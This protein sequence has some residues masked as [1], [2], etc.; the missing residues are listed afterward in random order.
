[1]RT[2]KN[3]SLTLLLIV[4]TSFVT[5]S[6]ILVTESFGSTP[7]VKK[8]SYDVKGKGQFVHATIHNGKVIPRVSLPVVT[9]TAKRNTKNMFATAEKGKSIIAVVN[10][11]E[12]VITS[13]KKNTNYK[14][15]AACAK[16][17][18]LPVVDLP[19]VLIVAERMNA[20]SFTWLKTNK[21]KIP[22]VDLPEV[23]ISADLPGYNKVAA[24]LYK[25]YYIPVVDLPE[26]EITAKRPND[27][28]T[29]ND[30]N[31]DVNNDNLNSDYLERVESKTNQ[32][33]SAIVLIIAKTIFLK[34]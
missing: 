19:E 4:L 1:M 14:L 22:V 10:L 7:A 33:L 21:H 32:S 26:V 27:L 2:L 6:A 18:N 20:G 25:G 16:D 12:I 5:Y 34:F 9:I 8:S 11:P 24:V 17:R 23:I 30:D 15:Y 31:R 3:L 28:I 13:M 29:T